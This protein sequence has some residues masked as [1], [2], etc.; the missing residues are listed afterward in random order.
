[1]DQVL[2]AFESEKT[3]RRIREILECSATAS[4]LVCRSGDQVR[5]LVNKRHIT[6][7]VC[8]FK[9]ADETAADVL[10]DLPPFC[11]MLVLAPQDQLDLLRSDRLLPLPAPTSRGALLEGVER[12]LQ[13]GREAEG[14]L[15]RRDG[16]ERETN[17]DYDAKRRTTLDPLRITRVP[18]GTF[19][20]W[21]RRR[22]KNK[23]PRL[24]NDRRVA[25]EIVGATA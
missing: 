12:L 21:L 5:R 15:S 23:V 25:E 18:P 22:G 19:L 2:V 16:A 1:M 11:A 3:C 4:C 9:L 10:E 24:S 20:A 13:M 7:V 17:S 14:T 8:G 6:A